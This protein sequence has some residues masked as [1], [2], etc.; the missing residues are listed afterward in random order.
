VFNLY[1]KH[2]ANEAVAGFGDFRIG[3]QVISTVK[4]TDDFV[5][6]AARHD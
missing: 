1:S 4:Y 5:L 3:G 2:F 6:L